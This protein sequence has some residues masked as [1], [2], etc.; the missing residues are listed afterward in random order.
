MAD[1]DAAKLD[2]VKGWFQTYYGPSNA[3]LVIAG[4]V[5]A[6]TAKEKVERYFGDI[7]AG[8]PV[9]RQETWV[10][11]T[12][13]KPARGDA[14]PGAAKQALQG[15]ERAAVGL[16]RRDVSRACRVGAE[17]RQV[18]PA[19]QAAGVRRADRDRR[20]RLPRPARDRR[21]LHGHGERPS[22]RG[23]RQGGARGKRGARTFPR[24][25]AHPGGTGPR[26]DPGARG[27]HPGRRAHR[28]LRRKVGRARAGRGLCRPGRFLH[29]AAAADRRGNHRAGARIRRALARRWRLHARGT[30]PSPSTPPP[31]PA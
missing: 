29:G 24:H 17:R 28:R 7:P 5:D 11:Q 18:V 20:R 30:T 26:Q 31:P 12:Q 16:V 15:V 8:P 14:G 1:L 19:V 21:T 27:I 6:K 23:S 10:A 4:D 9:A 3:V 25:R 22:R 13:R 2:D